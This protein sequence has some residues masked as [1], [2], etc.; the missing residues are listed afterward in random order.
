[1]LPIQTAFN[2]EQLEELYDRMFAQG[3]EFKVKADL[4]YWGKRIIKIENYESVPPTFIIQKLTELSFYYLHS[5]SDH[6]SER[7]KGIQIIKKI[8]TLYHFAGPGILH[9]P[10][11]AA[12]Y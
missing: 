3:Q 2:Q 9:A 7:L 12:V 11:F 6:T 8:H 5:S 10:I 1:M 4:T